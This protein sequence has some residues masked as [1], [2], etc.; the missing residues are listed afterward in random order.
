MENQAREKEE[1][2]LNP[3]DHA[4]LMQSWACRQHEKLILLVACGFI[5]FA[6]NR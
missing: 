5:L 3:S 4:S 1:R 2:E 6:R